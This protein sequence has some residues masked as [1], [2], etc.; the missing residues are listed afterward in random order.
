MNG[1]D[2]EVTLSTRYT[3]TGIVTA[4]APLEAYRVIMAMPEYI[5]LRQYIE[6]IDLYNVRNGHHHY[7]CPK[8][9]VRAIDTHPYSL[10]SF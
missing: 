4:S 9:A 10:V 6:R 3:K 1:Y 2:F 5:G 7:W 8:T